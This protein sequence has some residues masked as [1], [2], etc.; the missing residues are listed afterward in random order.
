MLSRHYGWVLMTSLSTLPSSTLQS[1]W[2]TTDCINTGTQFRDYV[3]NRLIFVM[4]LKR[5]S[6]YLKSEELRF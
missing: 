6:E 1:I 2:F 5:S 4:L 3:D